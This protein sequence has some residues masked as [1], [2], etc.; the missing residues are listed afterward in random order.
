M[1]HVSLQ[2]LVQAA[3]RVQA[4]W[5]THQLEFCFIGGLAVQHW[6]EP[7]QTGDVDAT[8]WTEF[9]KERPIIDRLLQNLTPRIED[10][11]GFAMVNRVLLVQEP[12]GIDTDVSLAAFPFEREVIERSELLKVHPDEPEIRL[13][14]PSDLVILKA[15]A[16]RSRDWQ[17]IRGI[18]I[19]SQILLD[20]DLIVREIT[21]LANLKEEPEIIDRLDQV[22]Y[23]TSN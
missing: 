6:G 8:V 18:L 9:G 14:G 2:D 7:R 20:W 11:A 13:C 3:V 16:N 12:G 1:T 19:R 22:R 4:I 10:A 15:F 23:D 5:Q 21:V 17:D